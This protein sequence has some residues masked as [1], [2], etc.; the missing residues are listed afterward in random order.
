MCDAGVILEGKGTLESVGR[1][2]FDKVL[3]V[4][5]GKPAAAELFGH[6]E[7]SIWRLAETI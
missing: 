1:E 3:A 4:A 2:I 6:K 7:F 5:N